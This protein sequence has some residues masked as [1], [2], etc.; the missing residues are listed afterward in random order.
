M[1]K[2]L[3]PATRMAVFLLML[4]LALAACGSGGGSSASNGKIT[5]NLGYFPN[6]T[7]AAAL[8]GVARGTYQQ[9]LGSRVA[10]QTKT[11]NAGPAEIE[12]LFAGDIDIGFAGPSPAVNGYI[13]SHSQALR[14]IA[15]ASSC[16]ALFVVR[17][18]AHITSAQGLANKKLATPQLGGTQDVALRYYLQQHGL[19]STE[20]GGNVQIVP[21]D[22]PTI[23]SLFKQGRI[24]GA[25][26][27]EPW[28]TR[29]IVEGHGQVF[30][31]ECTLWPNQ[32]FST[33]LVVARTPFLNQHTDLVTK[34]L[35]AEVETVQY[36]QQNQ[37]A[38]LGDRVIVF[39][40]R[41]GRIV[42]EFRIDLPRPRSL[43][44]HGLVD[45]SAEILAVLRE[46]MTEQENE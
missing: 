26:V 44:D 36:I 42:R 5:L 22:N 23:L 11:F 19:Q 7:H 18:G 41:P 9:A 29:L 38:A 37:Q 34:F 30:V 43:E 16:G 32:Q 17:P 2:P 14:I 39:S 3:T 1:K 31:D 15:G 27:P 40:P 45:Q 35:Q 8:V 13:K 25:W 33:T 4:S 20:K 28:A 24:D 12:A 46:A 6:L 10:L 21:T